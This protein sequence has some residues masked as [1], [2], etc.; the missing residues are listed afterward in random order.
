MAAETPDEESIRRAREWIRE[1]LDH[2]RPLLPAGQRVWHPEAAE[3]AKKVIA[4]AEDFQRII[5]SMDDGLEYKE[6]QD[7]FCQVIDEY[8]E[9]IG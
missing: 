1:R 5:L 3:T 4:D 7:G 6:L 2:V 8:R 9:V